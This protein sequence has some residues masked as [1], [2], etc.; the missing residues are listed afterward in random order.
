MKNTIK[1]NSPFW[2]K[3]LP[4]I[5]GVFFIVSGIANLLEA[6]HPISTLLFSMFLFAGSLNLVMYFYYPKQATI[7]WDDEKLVYA[8]QQLRSKKIL[9]K[10]IF[11]FRIEKDMLILKSDSHHGKVI[12]IKGFNYDDLQDLTSILSSR[13]VG[14]L[15]I[16]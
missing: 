6:D 2:V 13:I 3:H 14:E 16:A 8:G 4:L 10:D 11:E 12:D 7:Y 9:F 5:S 15:A 1:R